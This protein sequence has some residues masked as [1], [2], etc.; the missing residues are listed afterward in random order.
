MEMIGLI[1][2]M[3]AI[4]W[5]IIDRAKGTWAQ[6]SFSK[7]ITIAVSAAFAFGLSFSFGMDIVFASGL[8]K[9]VTPAGQI[10]TGF[11]LM[12]GSSAV[13]EV[14]TR[15]KTVPTNTVSQPN[16]FDGPEI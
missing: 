7:Y 8:F 6:V 16:E 11:V 5:Y 2:A 12:S 13:A 9:S 4:M 3:S 15:V 14:I 1:V 10:L